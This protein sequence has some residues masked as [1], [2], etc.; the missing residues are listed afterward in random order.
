MV[1]AMQSATL[2]AY[3]AQRS[4]AGITVTYSRGADSVSLTA[5]VGQS[6]FD[7]VD[8]MGIV[9]RIES[10]D[11]FVDVTKLILNSVTV[12]PGIGDSIVETVDGIDYKYE[13]MTLDSQPAWRYSDVHRY[14]LRIHTKQIVIT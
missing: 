2:A 9:E 14:A 7:E 1:T 12:L 4:A 6:S 13:V 3:K 10:R 11:Y 5:V 8:A